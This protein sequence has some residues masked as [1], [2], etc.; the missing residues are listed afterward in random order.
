MIKKIAVFSLIFCAFNSSS[1]ASFIQDDLKEVKTTIAKNCSSFAES[2]KNK[3]LEIEDTIERG[4][5]HLIEEGNDLLEY[6]FPS[7]T[8]N[9]KIHMPTPLELDI[10]T[11]LFNFSAKNGKVK[12]SS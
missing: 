5:H 1:E 10:K 7:S 11:S 3:L 12:F 8:V 2:S 9:L 4:A 6:L